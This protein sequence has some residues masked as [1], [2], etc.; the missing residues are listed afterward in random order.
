M[1]SMC[2]RNSQERS[3]TRAPL[4]FIVPHSN[5]TVMS[6]RHKF[7]THADGPCPRAGRSAVHI[8]ATFSRLKSAR[9]VRKVRSGQSGS[10]GR[11]VHDLATWSTRALTKWG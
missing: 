4:L 5:P 3:H 1:S 2:A 8:T 7:C 11:N 10:L 6:K 9:A